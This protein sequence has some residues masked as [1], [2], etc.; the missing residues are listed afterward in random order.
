MWSL[1]LFAGKAAGQQGAEKFPATVVCLS[2]RAFGT[3]ESSPSTAQN[4]EKKFG[5]HIPDRNLELI[6]YVKA[7]REKYLLN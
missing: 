4:F 3:L 6:V 1:P 2:K 7:F 5:R